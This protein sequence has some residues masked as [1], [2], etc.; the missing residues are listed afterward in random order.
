MDSSSAAEEGEVTP[1][2]GEQNGLKGQDKW[3]QGPLFITGVRL[4]V[5]FVIF[6]AVVA[7]TFWFGMPTLDE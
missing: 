5:L 6:T 2:L 7:G 3:Y 4:S 1:L